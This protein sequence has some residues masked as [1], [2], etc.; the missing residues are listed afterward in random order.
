MEDGRACTINTHF[1]I[2]AKSWRIDPGLKKVVPALKNIINIALID[3]LFLHNLHLRDTEFYGSIP[4]VVVF[5]GQTSM[6]DD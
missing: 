1:H 6:S 3:L 4:K 2:I 5:D